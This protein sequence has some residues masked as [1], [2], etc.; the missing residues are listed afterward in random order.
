MMDSVHAA[1]ISSDLFIVILTK[2]ANV[3]S[4]NGD[5]WFWL[6]VWMLVCLS[7]LAQQQSGSLSTVHAASITA[8]IGSS[9]PTTLIS[10]TPQTPQ[11]VTHYDRDSCSA[12]S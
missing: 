6:L 12:V 4:V 2:S 5:R 10:Q 9:P 11:Q 8:G 1:F 3:L 7:A